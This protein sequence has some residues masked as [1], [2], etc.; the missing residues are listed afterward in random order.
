VA[1][2]TARLA[3]T[4]PPRILWSIR[5]LETLRLIGGGACLAFKALALR[6]LPLLAQIQSKNNQALDTKRLNE[7]RSNGGLSRGRADPNGRRMTGRSGPWRTKSEGAPHGLE[8]GAIALAI[9]ACLA[10]LPS[11]MRTQHSTSDTVVSGNLEACFH[12]GRVQQKLL[13][14]LLNPTLTF[15]ASASYLPRPRLR[16]HD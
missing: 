2:P 13:Q 3:A 14:E 6:A 10:Y 7:R 11:L 12:M 15:P 5:W 4:G 16:P 8:T 9:A 1:T